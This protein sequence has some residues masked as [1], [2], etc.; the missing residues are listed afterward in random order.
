[1]ICLCYLDDIVIYANTQEE[2]LDRLKTVLDRLRD[3]G[4]KAKRSKCALFNE[5]TRF[6]GH[7]VS[8]YGNEPQPERIQAI[9]EWPRPLC[10]RDV[11]AFYG[12]ASYYRRFVKGF[13]NIAEPLTS[14]TK[15][16]VSFEWTN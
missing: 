16:N 10:L 8:Q 4:L 5:N 14:L 15:K 2:L 3:V 13:A 7:V 1:M 9:E 12:L 6:L 11:R